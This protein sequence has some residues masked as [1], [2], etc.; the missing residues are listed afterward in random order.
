MPV[1]RLGPLGFARCG[2]PQ[3]RGPVVRGLAIVRRS[4]TAAIAATAALTSSRAT[5]RVHVFRP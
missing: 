1:G 2:P 4:S 5:G 3:A